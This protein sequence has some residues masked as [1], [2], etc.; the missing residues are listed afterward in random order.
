MLIPLTVVNFWYTDIKL[1]CKPTSVIL[2]CFDRTTTMV[3]MVLVVGDDDEGWESPKVPLNFQFCIL[4]LMN[5]RVGL[6]INFED[7]FKYKF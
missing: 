3:M 4:C 7:G 5:S 1:D 2:L 6:N